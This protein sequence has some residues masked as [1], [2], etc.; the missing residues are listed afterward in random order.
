MRNRRLLIAAALALANVSRAMALIRDADENLLYEA[1]I[2]LEN[3]YLAGGHRCG[4]FLELLT[5]Y[6]VRHF[7]CGRR[8]E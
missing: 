6:E 5:V 7:P 3:D 1:R 4:F 8:G 2:L